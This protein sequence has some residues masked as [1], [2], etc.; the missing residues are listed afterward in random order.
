MVINIAS[1]GGRT[2][3]LDTAREL[4]RHGHTVRF[5]SYVPTKRAVRYGLPKEC[6]FSLF[7]LA[8]PFLVLFKI[9]GHTEALTYT[10]WRIYDIITAFILKPCDVFIGQSPMH[11]HSINRAKKK[12]GAITILECGSMHV[13]DFVRILNKDPQLKGKPCMSSKA[14]QRDIKSYI[15]PD[16]LSV[17]SIMVRDSFIAHGIEESKIFINN[18]GYDPFQFYPTELET[19]HYDI[20]MVG[21]W[22]YRKGADLITELCKQYQ[23]RFLHVGPLLMPFPAVYNMTHIDAVDQTQLI[24]YYSKAKVFLLPSREEGLALVQL[25]ALACGLPL[26]CSRFSGGVE[27]TKYCKS[28]DWVIECKSFSIEEIHKAINK[29]LSL[30]ATQH[31]K[32]SIFVKDATLKAYGNR[33]NDFLTKIY[34]KTN[35]HF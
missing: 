2:H 29:A 3:M 5:Y 21:Q 4:A 14:E 17:G 23:Y 20:L 25:Q 31:G 32:R 7:Y 19:Q 27:L 15:S 26:V 33:Y 6:S 18:Y 28:S 24:K 12:F 11:I 8:L 1:F 22:S 10:Y 13:K 16:Y 34:S 30:A 35:H 9:F